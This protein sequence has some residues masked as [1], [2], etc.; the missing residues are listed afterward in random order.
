MTIVEVNL[1]A[2]TV[3]EADILVSDNVR[4]YFIEF[5]FS[6]DWENFSKVAVFQ[7]VGGVPVEM[8]LQTNTVYIPWEVLETPNRQVA[9]GVYGVNENG[10]ILSSMPIV[11]GNVNQGTDVDNEPYKEFTPDLIDQLLEWIA[12]G[13]GGGGIPGPQGPPGEPGADATIN[14]VNTLEIVAGENIA[15]DQEDDVLTISANVSQENTISSE[16]IQTMVVI[17]ESE[18]ASLTEKISTTLYII[19]EES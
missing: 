16:E 6:E 12:Q 10:D 5:S 2:M 14:G 17:S 8:A 1:R 13:G 19:P 18:Y 7:S 4:T 9:V 15:I 11:L 3:K